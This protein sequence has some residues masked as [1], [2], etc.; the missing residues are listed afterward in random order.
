MALFN[1]EALVRLLSYGKHLGVANYQPFQSTR[2]M[3]LLL[4]ISLG[5]N[6]TVLPPQGKKKEIFPSMQASY[7]LQG[8]ADSRSS[9]T[10]QEGL[11]QE[12]ILLTEIRSTT[13]KL[14]C[15]DIK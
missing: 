5:A 12:V 9:Q 15:G 8:Q 6:T 1:L 2:K 11:S 3:S 13:G 14:L 4:P 10:A 7:F